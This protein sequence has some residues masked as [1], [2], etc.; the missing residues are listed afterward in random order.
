MDSNEEIDQYDSTFNRN[1]ELSS[2]QNGLSQAL[3]SGLFKNERVGA[4][5]GSRWGDSHSSILQVES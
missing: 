2:R 1:T 3:P 5:M 4:R